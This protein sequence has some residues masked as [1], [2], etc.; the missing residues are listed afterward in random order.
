MDAELAGQVAIVTGA[1]RG[2]GFAA[3]R[4]VAA[5]GAS[6]AIV[7]RDEQ[8]ADAAVGRLRADGFDARPLVVDLTDPGSVSS[9]FEDLVASLGKVDILVNIAATYPQRVISE[10]DLDFWHGVIASSLDA[11]FIA[12][13]SVLPHMKRSGYGRIVNTSSGAYYLAG[14]G[15]AAYTAAKAG[16]IGFTRVLAREAG[17]FGITANTVMPGLIVTENVEA[18]VEHTTMEQ[19]VDQQCIGRL[20]TPDDIAHGIGYLVSPHAGFIT[21]QILNIGG[22]INF[23]G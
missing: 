3:A 13:Q 7:D 21:G 15:W 9:G 20:G 1:A 2:I 16:V 6:V 17:P 8:G 18:T 4:L 14:K 5:R 22:G 10:M 23:V 19:T 11:S 12:S